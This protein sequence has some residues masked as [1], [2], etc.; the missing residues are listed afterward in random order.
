MLPSAGALACLPDGCV[1][2]GAGDWPGLS[3][4]PSFLAQVGPFLDSVWC[5]H[6]LSQT[7]NPKVARELYGVGHLPWGPPTPQSP[8][9]A[10]VMGALE[11]PLSGTL[12]TPQAWKL[13][14]WFPGRA[15]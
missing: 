6:P 13:P 8:G 5:E 10:P 1:P 12:S 14:T 2:D 15:V 3:T 9:A 4:A 7:V 11:G